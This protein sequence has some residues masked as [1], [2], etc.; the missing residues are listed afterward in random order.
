MK[1]AIK[2]SYTEGLGSVILEGMAAG[3][4]V[5]GSNAGGIP[6]IIDNELTGVLIEPGDADAL[7]NAITRIAQDTSLRELFVTN[8][9]EKLKTFD[10][11]YTANQ[12]VDVYEK[13]LR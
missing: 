6:D 5:V 7:A 11:N 12:Y 3:L 9:Q 8:G 4:P 10:I 2:A 1:I 13:A